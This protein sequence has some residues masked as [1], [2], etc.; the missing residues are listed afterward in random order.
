MM[1]LV[2]M[3]N[4]GVPLASGASAPPPPPPPPVPLLP[5]A[6]TKITRAS[7]IR[8]VT[9]LELGTA[10]GTVGHEATV[11][12]EGAD[13]GEVVADRHAHLV[14]LRALTGDDRRVGVGAGVV[15]GAAPRDL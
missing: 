1:S 4:T 3:S 9:P 14:R 7:E 15:I 2:L 13:H 12:P 11:R 6:A 8:I 5:H 10:T